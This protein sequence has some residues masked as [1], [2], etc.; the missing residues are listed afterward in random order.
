MLDREAI[1]E[2]ILGIVDQKTDPTPIQERSGTEE[3]ARVLKYSKEK[4]GVR[5]DIG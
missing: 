4:Q 2:M 1:K 3:W 5:L